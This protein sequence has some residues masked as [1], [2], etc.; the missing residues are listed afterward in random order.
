MKRI[1][2]RIAS[3]ALLSRLARGGL[4]SMAIKV[5]GA[6]LS[7]AMTAALAQAMDADAFGRFSFAFALAMTASI[8]AGL[9]LQ[10]G[11]LRWRPEHEVDG[12]PHLAAAAERWGM[13]LTL[14]A[15]AAV[16]LAGAG[17]WIPR[18]LGLEAFGP[19]AR[20]D[21]A[22]MTGAGALAM[23]L[24][25]SEYIASALRARGSTVLALAPR[26]VAWRAALSG[27]TV[28]I[29]AAG[30]SLSAAEALWLAAGLLAGFA[31]AQALW[32]GFHRMHLEFDFGG[33]PMAAE[34]ARARLRQARPM[35]G[36]TVLGAVSR[37]LDV[38]VLGLFVAPAL[39]GAYFAAASIAQALMLLLVSANM[40]AAPLI[41]RMHRAGDAA[42]MQRMMKLIMAGMAPAIL[43]GYGLMA[44]L[45]PQLL[46]IFDPSYAAYSDVLLIVA[47]GAAFNALGGPTGYTMQLAGQEHAFLKVMLRVYVVVAA[48]QFALVPVLGIYGAAVIGAAGHLGW[49]L[50]ARAICRARI[51]VDPTVLMFFTPAAR[52]PRGAPAE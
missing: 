20:F 26:D 50:W 14:M 9:G 46:A 1:F 42:G 3:D 29:G 30:L 17:F 23:A 24:A 21:A 38:L 44:L 49:N 25:V 7:I 10:T 45:G 40:V 52:A 16:L 18:A 12:E 43:V 51:G 31:L 22:A 6:G 48:A 5:G 37:Y 34:R 32:A 11:I 36:A 35:W 47:A 28:A 15:G 27:A 2:D 33:D 39:T 8:V 13:T 41:A 4:W 19:G